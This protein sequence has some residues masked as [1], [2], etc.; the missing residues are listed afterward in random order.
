M[1]RVT[2]YGTSKRPLL[3]GWVILWWGSTLPEG[4]TTYGSTPRHH[5]DT[6]QWEPQKRREMPGCQTLGQRNRFV[7]TRAGCQRHT[8]KWRLVRPMNELQFVQ[9]GPEAKRA[10]RATATYSL[11][12]RHPAWRAG[13]LSQKTECGGRIWVLRRGDEGRGYP[14]RVSNDPHKRTITEKQRGEMPKP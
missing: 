7:K 13:P 4:T 6:W 9:F 12:R 8:Q 5:D 3:Q 14:D 2:S 10:K 1:R 11:G